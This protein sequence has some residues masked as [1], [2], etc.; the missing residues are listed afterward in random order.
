MRSKA[1]KTPFIHSYRYQKGNVKKVSW[2]KVYEK[3]DDKMV[4]A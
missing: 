3:E 2:P 1:R 4:G